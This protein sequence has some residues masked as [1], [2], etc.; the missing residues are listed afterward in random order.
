MGA[1]VFGAYVL[2]DR[3][4]AGDNWIVQAFCVAVP[5]GIGALAYV[6]ISHMLGSREAREFLGA[7]TRRRTDSDGDDVAGSPPRR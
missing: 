4:V 6:A 7:Y 1:Y 3:L 5:T 2:L